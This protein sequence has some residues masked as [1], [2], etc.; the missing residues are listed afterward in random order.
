MAYT[1]DSIWKSV[2]WMTICIYLMLVIFGSAYV[3]PAM[4]MVRLIF[5]VST[6]G[7]ENSLYGSVALWGSDLS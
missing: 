5:L 3:E 1:N 6:L 2:D 4:I 7:Q